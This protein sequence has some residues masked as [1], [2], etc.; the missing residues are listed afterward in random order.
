MRPVASRAVEFR[1]VGGSNPLIVISTRVNGVPTRV[2]GVLAPVNGTRDY[3]FLLDSGATRSM[4]S[5]DVAFDLGIEAESHGEGFGAGGSL[6]MPFALVRS[7]EVGRARQEKVDVVISEGLELIGTRLKTK[8]DGAIGFDFLRNFRLTIDYQQRLLHFALPS[9]DGDT[10]GRS[11]ESDRSDGY[12]DFTLTPT[13][14]LILLQAVVHDEGPFQ[15]VLDT[16]A[17]RTVVTPELV[18]RLRIPVGEGISGT[19]MGGK[20]DTQCATVNSLALGD[21]TV[22]DLPVVVGRFLDT[23][24]AAVGAKLDGIIGNNLLRRYRVTIDCP[25]RRLILETPG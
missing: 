24:S 17:S 2:N 11:D 23:I 8:I 7:I 12:V 9:E 20:L 14:P 16:G 15:F 18:E 22:R 13:E 5:P 25:A 19:G 4:I 3:Q 10:E 1:P 21:T 6:R